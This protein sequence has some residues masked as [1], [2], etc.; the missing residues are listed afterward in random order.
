M[1]RRIILLVVLY[2]LSFLVSCATVKDRVSDSAFQAENLPVRELKILVASDGSYSREEI[3]GILRESSRVFEE[4]VGIRFVPVRYISLHWEKRDVL[5][6]LEK[7]Y[8]STDTQ[9]FDMAIGFSRWTPGEF[10]VRNLVGSWEGCIDDTYRRYIILKNLN[11]HTL[12]H[13]VAHAFIFEN[14]HS[15]NGLMMP[16]T[17]QVLPFVPL[18]VQSLYLAE[19][20]RREVLVNKWREFSEIPV[21]ASR[22]HTLHADTQARSAM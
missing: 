8:Y 12:L 13:E 2:S 15:S 9:G 7:I 1:N 22:E 14:S 10:L 17:F 19:E 18:S 21:I 5:S 11:K 3:D 20:D 6:M 16:M 4:Q